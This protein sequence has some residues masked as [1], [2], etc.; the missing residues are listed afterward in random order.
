M[1][2]PI[3][4]GLEDLLS[5]RATRQS[6]ELEEVLASCPELRVQVDAM[7]EQAEWMQALRA[8][9][10][11]DPSP[12]FYARVMDRIEAQSSN[13]FWSVF[14]EPVFAKRLMYA[15]LA[16]FVVLTSAVWQTGSDPVLHESNPMTIMAGAELPAA[17]GDDQ[18]HDRAVVL[19]NLASFGSSEAV[20]SLP[21]SSD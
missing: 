9:E 6:K 15:S 16:L 11:I 8:P 3:E 5:G 10:Q 4:D 17:P 13:S 20:A 7:R 19:A 12:G 14:L 18:N 1:H 21:M 2:K